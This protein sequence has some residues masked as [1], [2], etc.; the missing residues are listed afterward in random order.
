MNGT[1][2]EYWLDHVS[3]AM[4][5]DA[6]LQEALMLNDVYARLTQRRA[7]MVGEEFE[8]APKRTFRVVINAEIVSAEDFEYDGLFVHYFVELP[9]GWSA[10]KESQLSGMTHRYAFFRD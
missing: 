3:T 1:C 10:T 9:M 8:R 7:A 5:Y 6:Q 4:H 2:Y